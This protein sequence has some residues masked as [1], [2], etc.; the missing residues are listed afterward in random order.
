MWPS[1]SQE[2]RAVLENIMASQNK[3]CIC[4]FLKVWGFYSRG[5]GTYLHG[6]KMAPDPKYLPIN[7]GF[8]MSTG[9]LNGGEDHI[10]EKMSC[11]MGTRVLVTIYE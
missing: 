7:R 8:D 11:A 2:G 3:S 5:Y 9:F 1:P 4:K 6:R 10:N